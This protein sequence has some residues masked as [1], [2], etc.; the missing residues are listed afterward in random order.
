M[1][2]RDILAIGTSAGGVDAL[3][4]LASRFPAGFPASVLMVIHLS[5]H[6]Q[7]T[8]DAILTEA[9]PLP[10]QF[11]KDGTEIARAEIYIAPPDSH[12]LVEGGC[13]RLGQG[14]R[15]NNSRPAIDPLFRSVAL[16]CGARAVGA[17]LTGT[18]GDGA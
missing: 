11:A 3:R 8:L 7:S 5:P 2:N 14:G 17:V 18:L 16:C 9:G 13:L 1:S 10:A 6:F 4:F 15:E 12:L